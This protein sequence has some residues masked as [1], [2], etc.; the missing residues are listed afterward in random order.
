MK[1][2]LYVYIFILAVIIFL[3]NRNG[4]AYLLEFVGFV[5]FGDKIGHF[6]LAGIFSFLFNSIFDAREINFGLIKFLLGNVAVLTIVTVEEIS[7]IYVSG[8]TFD[9]GDLF[10][11]YLGIYIFGKLARITCERKT[12]KLKKNSVKWR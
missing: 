6:L 8:R 2:A 10:F 7:Q 11:D 12:L 1:I 4:T 9:W 3:A 5:P